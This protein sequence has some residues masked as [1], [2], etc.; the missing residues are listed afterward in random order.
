MTRARYLVS[1]F[2]HVATKI[3][4]KHSGTVSAFV[5]PGPG[6]LSSYR[7]IIDYDDSLSDSI[8]AENEMIKLI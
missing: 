3:I 2:T 4:P 5:V 7:A 1:I 6:H 8:M